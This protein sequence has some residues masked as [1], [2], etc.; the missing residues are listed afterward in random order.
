MRDRCGQCD[1]CLK[2]CPTQAF[3]GP[4][5]LDARRC[6]SYLTIELKGAMPRH[7]RSLVGNHIFGCDI[8]Q[9]VCPY[10]VKAQATAEAAFGPRP[11]LHAPQLIPLL[12]LTD[13]EFAPALSR[14]PDSARETARLPT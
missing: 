9:D 1:L 4:Y 14:Q 11:G 6:I 2:A 7:L 8:C 10:N 12:K 3:V 13:A 5:I